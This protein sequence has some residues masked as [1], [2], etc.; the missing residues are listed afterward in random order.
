MQTPSR[1]IRWGILGTGYISRAFAEGLR[2]LPGAQLVAIASRTLSSAQQFAREFGVAKAYGSYGELVQDAEVDVVYIG[3]PNSRHRDDCLLCL[4]AGKPVLCEKPFAL[5]AREAGEVIEFARKQHL[6]CMEAMWMRFLPLVQRVRQMVQSG[7]IGEVCTL[8]AEFGYPA[9]FDPSSRLF[10]RELGGGALLDRGVYP[11]SLAYFLLG[12]P[13]SVVSQAAIASTGVDEQ[14]SYLLKYAGGQLAMLS[15]NLRTYA[16]NEAVITGTRGQIRIHAPFYKPHQL[17]VATFA[18]AGNGSSQASGGN[19]PS[20]LKQTITS[21]VQDNSLL[22][23]L[24]LQFGDPFLKRLRQPTKTILEPY[25]GNGYGYEAAEVMRCLRS[26][27]I[28]SRIMPLDET[29]AIQKTM[30]EMRRQWG[31]AYPQDEI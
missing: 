15:A 21:A 20:S 29:L 30:D 9:A 1:T 27:E 19:R 18:A 12:E 3:T 4:E 23:R 13:E 10:N 31:L 22:Q 26:G 8:T 11:L 7:A 6:F 5:N 24:Y 28:E 2:P 17:S 14:S 16:S 25:A